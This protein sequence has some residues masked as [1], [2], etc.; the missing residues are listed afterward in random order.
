MISSDDMPAW[1]CSDCAAKVTSRKP[2]C[3]CYHM[4]ICEVCNEWKEVTQPRDYGYPKV[5]PMYDKVKILTNLENVKRLYIEKGENYE[6]EQ[7]EKKIV[8]WMTYM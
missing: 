3:A 5:K 1:I 4:D 6:A 2:C 8:E 7:I